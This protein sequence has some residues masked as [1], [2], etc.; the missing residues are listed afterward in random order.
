[1]LRMR[2]CRA[3]A[4]AILL[5]ALAA[6]PGSA[7]DDCLDQSDAEGR[8]ILRFTVGSR[9]NSLR[10]IQFSVPPGT[11]YSTEAVSRAMNAVRARLAAEGS[12]ETQ[13]RGFIGTR[14]TE[15]CPRQTAE[16]LEVAITVFEVRLPLGNP[17]TGLLPATR[18]T[19]PSSLA[20]TPPALRLLNPELG[21]TNDSALGLSPTTSFKTDLLSVRDLV[22]ERRRERPAWT[23]PL[24]L[25]GRRGLNEDTYDAVLSVGVAHDAPVAVL[26]HLDVHADYQ[27]FKNPQGDAWLDREVV[28]AGSLIRLK[29]DASVF[30]QLT[31]I[32]TVDWSTNRRAAVAART[33][34]ETAFSFLGVA[35][36]A[37]PLGPLRWASLIETAAVEHSDSYRRFSTMVGWNAQV[38]FSKVHTN[39]TLGLELNA[40]AGQIWGPAPEH[41]RYF[42]GNAGMDFL[43][44]ATD[45]P[46][47]PLRLA[48]PNLRSFGRSQAQTAVGGARS[49]WG[50]NLNVAFPV[51][52]W[53]MPLIPRAEVVGDITLNELVYRQGTTSAENF[54]ATYYENVEHRSPEA[55]ES[56]AKRE[57][58][59]IEPSLRFIT[60]RANLYSVKPLLM[61]DAVHLSPGEHTPGRT[62]HAAGGGLQLTI[63]VARIEAGYMWTVDRRPEDQH[64]NFVMRL[65]FDNIF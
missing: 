32:P 33:T 63:V 49:Y 1:M 29:P 7:A 2:G 40:S 9:W 18:S 65:V 23:L 61:Y 42:A 30:R 16:G 46:A 21:I 57:V 19:S 55:A 58:A 39:R 41:A 17:I 64:G 44:E 51:G 36:A 4:I 45:S 50:L 24:S 12:A 10:D 8:P 62:F 60:R 28:R 52:R 59:R 37:I 27:T 5:V 31:L 56:K 25:V 3:P 47:L 14:Y 53:L 43:L 35:D 34:H 26:Q 15:A 54:L 6:T 20:G 11:A 22:Q 38:P 48:A 13:T